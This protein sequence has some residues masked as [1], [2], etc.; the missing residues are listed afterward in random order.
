[1]ST[2]I[3]LITGLILGYCFGK[4]DTWI[5]LRNTVQSKVK[6]VDRE[7]VAKYFANESAVKPTVTIIPRE[8]FKDAFKAKD[9]SIED[10]LK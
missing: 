5:T 7:L 9:V 1:M 10:M 4:L 6:E 2:A 3:A 8:D